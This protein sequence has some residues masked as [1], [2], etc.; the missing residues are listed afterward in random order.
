MASCVLLSSDFGVL[1]HGHKSVPKAHA[2][3][4]L[5]WHPGCALL[6][7]TEYPVASPSTTGDQCLQLGNRVSAIRQCKCRGSWQKSLK[8][9]RSSRILLYLHCPVITCMLHISPLQ[10]CHRNPSL[11]LQTC[12][13]LNLALK[14]S[15]KCEHQL[16]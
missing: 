2:T 9:G 5:V 16:Q 10:K 12:L 7:I 4:S 6:W 8:L 13:V 14:C 1:A 3:P 15:Q 11:P